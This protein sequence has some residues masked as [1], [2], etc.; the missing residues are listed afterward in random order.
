MFV[1]MA[2]KIVNNERLARTM[3]DIFWHWGAMYM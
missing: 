1:Y 3:S 2:A